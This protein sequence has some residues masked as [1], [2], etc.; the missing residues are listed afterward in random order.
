MKSTLAQ[1]ENQLQRLIEKGVARLFPGG[2]FAARLTDSLLNAMHKHVSADENGNLAAPNEYAINLHPDR[3]REIGDKEKVSAGLALMLQEASEKTG[4]KLS[5]QPLV[6][7]LGDAKIKNG[8]VS[9]LAQLRGA[10]LAS[11]TKIPVISPPLPHPEDEPQQAFLIVYSNEIFP[12]ER[13]VTNI[14]RMPD[15][16]LV[17]DDLRVSRKH[18]QLRKI[19]GQFVLFDLGSTQGTFVNGEAVN[20]RALSPGDII[21]LGGVSLMFGQDEN[22]HREY[23]RPLSASRKKNT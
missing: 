15:N 6:F 8:E 10:S 1:V 21:S 16:D 7:L 18:A 22:G 5:G 2:Q 3:L 12:L 19:R 23:T 4:I 14:G 20:Q 11:T 9:V 13:A 17:F